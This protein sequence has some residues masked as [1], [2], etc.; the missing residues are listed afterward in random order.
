VRSGSD[1]GYSVFG[2]SPCLAKGVLCFENSIPTRIERS[3][4]WNLAAVTEIDCS[5]ERDSKI[6]GFL[7]VA[8]VEN[9]NAKRHKFTDESILEHSTFPFLAR[10][11]RPKYPPRTEIGQ[12]GPLSNSKKML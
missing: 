11:F 5:I 4:C 1:G 12:A 7:S 8:F 6:V 10:L 2:L 9:Q 3:R